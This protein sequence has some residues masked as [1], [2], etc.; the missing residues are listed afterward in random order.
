MK[1]ETVKIEAEEK[2]TDGAEKDEFETKSELVAVTRSQLNEVMN[3]LF[4]IHSIGALLDFSTLS[5][6]DC[7]HNV[8]ERLHKA[9]NLCDPISNMARLL[10]EKAAAAV[11]ALGEMEDLE[12]ISYK[13]VAT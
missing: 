3:A 10:K 11:E 9:D 6:G 7:D 13:E 1:K 8:M 2:G 5:S 12:T 4:S